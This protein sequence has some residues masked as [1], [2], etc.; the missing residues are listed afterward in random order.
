MK[1][2]VKFSL[3]KKLTAMIVFLSV[4]L[5]LVAILVS[6]RIFSSTMTRY[7]KELGT[8]LVR[9]LASQLDADELDYYYETGEMD[10]NYYK[11]QQ[12][13]QDLV[14]SNNVEYLYVVRPNGVGV[15][16]LFDSD[17]EVGEGGEYYDGGYC[18]LGTYV[19]L[20]GGFADNLDKLLAG[21]EVEPIIQPDAGFGWLMTAMVPVLHEDGTMAG[22][23]MADISMYDVMHTSQTF[24]I[25]LVVLLV[26]L[27]VA[28]IVLFLTILRRKVIQPIDQLTQATG[29]FIQNN[30]AELAA[31]T[32]TVN[33]PEIR[34]GDEV[35]ELAN[36]F[37]KME[38]DMI[39]YIRSFMKITAEKERIGA[40]LNV[41]TQI[42]ADMLPR[43]FPAFPERQEFDIYATMNPAK[44][45]GGD[46]YDFFL[47]DDDHLAVVIA[48]V[49][50]KG[51][52]AALFMVIA[53]TLIKNHAQNKEAPGEVFTNTNEQLCEG[54]DAGLFVTAWMGIL[55]IST[56]HFVYV[57]AGHNPPL[58]R[59]AG[60]SFEWLKSRPGFVLAGMEGVRYRENEM[61][62]A[63][64]DVLYLYTD[65]VTEATD[66][67][68]QLF[69]EERL[70]T[71]LNEQPMLPVG[72]M[73][74]KIKGCIDSF[75]GEAEQ[76]DDITMLGLEYLKRGDGT[77]G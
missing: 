18:A 64:G 71:A 11:T 58:L 26:A 37:R 46:F 6:Y 2:K 47:V 13:I 7:Y 61:E 1:Q 8:N 48:D 9:T 4:A 62:L 52:P 31:G 63:P 72:Q 43:I 55:Q 17:M 16:F 77:D 66:A 56:G 22:Y 73:L 33:V 65:G 49:S 21:E 41:A 45:V 44:E 20:V 39:S 19:D 30:E 51:V 36:S 69:G 50:G 70:Q 12:F 75:V 40:E 29:A 28:F 67:H 32:A 25:T 38:E 74:S 3:G 57:N 53:K 5:S 54:N 68:Q 35:E 34:T 42:Q 60:G 23:V 10:E 59:R 14:A 27:T 76:F 15:T 24:L